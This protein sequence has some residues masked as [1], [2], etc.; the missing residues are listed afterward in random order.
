MPKKMIPEAMRAG[1]VNVSC[2]KIKPKNMPITGKA[3]PTVER[4]VGPQ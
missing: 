3:H 1:K 4:A 2:R